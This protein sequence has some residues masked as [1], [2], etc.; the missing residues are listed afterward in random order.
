MPGAFAGGCLGIE[1][2]SPSLKFGPGRTEDGTAVALDG[3]T[4]L[5]RLPLGLFH[6]TDELVTGHANLVAPE[7]VPDFGE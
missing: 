1:I 6:S 2:D 3:E 4:Q 7:V 5:G